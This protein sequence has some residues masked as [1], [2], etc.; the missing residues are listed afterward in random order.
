MS[1]Q[2]NLH[3]TD[4][5]KFREQYLAELAQQVAIDDKNLQA[6]KI[7]KKVN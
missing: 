6:N 1:G 3:P 2:P 4:A 5:S 7:Y